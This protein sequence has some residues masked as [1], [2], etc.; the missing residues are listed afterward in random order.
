MTQVVAMLGAGTM[1]A[2]MAGNLV[3]AG[4]DV[5][6][7]NRS[8]GKAREAAVDGGTVADTPVEAVRDADFV[9]TMLFDGDSVL[10]VMND[11]LPHLAPYTLWLQMTTVGPAAQARLEALADEAGLVIVDAP[12]LGTRGPAIDGKLTI[13]AAGP[14]AVRERCATIFDIVGA[15]T[16]W[17]DAPQGGQRLK[18]VA[19]GWVLTATEAIAEALRL[20]TGLGLDPALFV[21]AI[22]GTANDLPYAHVK[23]DAILKGDFTPNFALDAARKDA[24]L[25]LDAAGGV[26]VA[27]VDVVERHLEQASKLGHGDSDVSAIA[28]A[29]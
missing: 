28:L 4:C 19:N 25:I 16:V 21:D 9:I 13:L 17:I 12:V 26:N 2:P 29:Y 18:L 1:G 3:R 20:A 7:W 22:S 23:A 14:G 11:V 8:A 27:L 24:R 6:I 10:D 5:R 15:R